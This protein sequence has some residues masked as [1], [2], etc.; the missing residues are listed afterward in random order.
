MLTLSGSDNQR[1][2][3]QPKA[4]ELD[5]LLAA[6]GVRYLNAAVMCLYNFMSDRKPQPEVIFCASGFFY[7]VKTVE[8]LFFVLIGNTNAVIFDG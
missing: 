8:N 4:I 1:F 3:V 2:S 6:F 5:T 7:P